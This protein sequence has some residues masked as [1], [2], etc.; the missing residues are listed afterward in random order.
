MPTIPPSPTKV[1]NRSESMTMKYTYSI[2][3]R[4]GSE[5]YDIRCAYESYP[6]VR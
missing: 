1:S 5:G 3:L 4:I 6:R 2:D